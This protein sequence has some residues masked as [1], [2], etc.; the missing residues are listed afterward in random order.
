VFRTF[1]TQLVSEPRAPL[2]VLSSRPRQ[3][4]PQTFRLAQLWELQ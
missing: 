4:R 2:A 1:F 3:R